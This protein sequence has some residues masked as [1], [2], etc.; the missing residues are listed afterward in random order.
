M[1]LKKY[2]L[3]S[4]AALCAI[5]FI[6]A[7][8]VAQH[9]KADY[10][11]YY[12]SNSGNDN[13]PGTIDAPFQTIQKINSLNLK[14]HSIVYFKA[15][16]TFKGKLII[17]MDQAE[18][19]DQWIAFS[20]YGDGKATLN[21]DSGRAISIYKSAN[22]VVRNLKLTGLGRKTGNRENGLAIINS[23]NIK[24]DNMDISGFQKSG[25]L[26]DSSSSVYCDGVF[27]RDNGSAGI[28]VEGRNSKKDSRNIKIFD[29]RAENNPGDPT[30]LDNH[31]GNGIVVGHC[32]KVT[33]EA[34][35]ATNNGWD[36]PRIGNG[37]VGIWCYEADSVTIR[38]CL[39]YNNK[40]SKGGAD[41]GGFDFDGGTT[42]SIIENCFS[43]GNQGSGFCIFQYWGASPWHDNI[44]RNNVSENDGTVSDSQ[45]GLY[46]WNSSDDPKQFYN[47][48]VYGNIV[49]NTK[50]AAIS[51]SDK[52]ENGGFD[53]YH[54]V[55][56]GKDSLIKGRDILGKC[57]FEGN[58]WWSLKSGFNAWGIKSFK[59]WTIKYHQERKNE[60][61]IG[62]NINP[63]FIN[64][65]LRAFKE[66]GKL[67]SFRGYLFSKK[68]TLKKHFGGNLQPA[69]FLARANLW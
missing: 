7:K 46:I 42:N 56:V 31:S 15:G 19:R 52:S 17:R 68:S 58:D 40:T 38:H 34:C 8:T 66:I 54:N 45:A 12:V 59:A 65:D 5:F 24:V 33:I 63:D 60:N 14:P 36:M 27:V 39:S 67:N 30:K 2:L 28:T 62:W 22:V 1:I 10:T 44:I 13:N 21:A 18:A 9:K 55:F 6:G 35:T 47:C 37:P 61:L 32:T 41:G 57:K 16:E 48:K 3:G 26:I 49:Y 29:C 23:E 69:D 20:S 64:P 11:K 43:Y 51:F 4:F 50:V 25:L 53:F